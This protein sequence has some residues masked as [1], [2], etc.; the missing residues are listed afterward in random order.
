MIHNHAMEGRHIEK[1]ILIIA[2]T[3]D[4]HAIVVAKRIESMSPY[5]AI[6]W[7]SGTFPLATK[8][9]YYNTNASSDFKIIFDNSNINLSDIISIW[10]R[11]PHPFKLSEFIQSDAI[12]SFCKNESEMFVLGSIAGMNIPIINDPLQQATACRKPYQISSAV[13]AKLDIP[14]TLMTNDSV[15]ATVFYEKHKDECI[16]KPFD[17]PPWR[18]AETRRMK[19][20]YLSNLKSLV[21]SPIILQQEIKNGRNIRINVFDKKIF[22]SEIL[23]DKTLYKG[24][25]WRLAPNYECIEHKLPEELEKKIII[26]MKIIKLRYGCFDFILHEKRGYVFLEVNPAGQ[27]LFVEIDNNQGLSSAMA[28]ILINP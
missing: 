6:I 11:R 1:V 26:F 2:P 3:D 23:P 16:Y 13:R 5:K 10:W 8:I 7:D 9:S 27:F 15:E 4:F 24:I 21:Y 14:D 20:E 17:S 28:E 25:D 22:A 18:I 12:R 19:K